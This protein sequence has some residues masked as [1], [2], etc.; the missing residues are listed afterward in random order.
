MRKK[1]TLL[2]LIINLLISCSLNDK[3]LKESWWKYGDG[4]HI[5]DVINFEKHQVINDTIFLD[6]IPKAILINKEGS[7]LGFT[8][9]TIIVKDLL[10]D[11][12]GTYYQ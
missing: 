10:S 9:R 7:I 3:Q 5:G 6:N 4:F 2:A 11:E 8:D 12:T 1:I